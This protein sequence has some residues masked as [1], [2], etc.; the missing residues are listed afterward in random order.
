MKWISLAD[1]WDMLMKLSNE[2]NAQKRGFASSR[3]YNNVNTHFLGLCGEQAWSIESGLPMRYDLLIDGDG[4]KDFED[5]QVKGT[6]HWD[7]PSLLEFPNPKYTSRYYVLVGINQKIKSA[8]IPGF[9]VKHELF[10][11]PLRDRGYGPR[12]SINHF[13]LRSIEALKR[14]I[15]YA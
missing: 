5:I 10:E 15:K 13:K 3:Y 12:H 8:W 4:G 6:S 9:C 14:I 2:R 7:N 11:A 1:Y